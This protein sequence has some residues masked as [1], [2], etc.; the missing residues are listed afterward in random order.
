[1]TRVLTTIHRI[2]LPCAMMFVVPVAV[3]FNTLFLRDSVMS[4]MSDAEYEQ[5][6]ESFHAALEQLQVGETLEWGGT[7]GAH[8]SITLGEDFEYS[9]YTCRNTRFE[10]AVGSQRGTGELRFCKDGNGEWKIL[11]TPR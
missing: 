1:M 11:S 2:V 8:G 10:N 7:D 6:R 9:G 3:A 4:E 5:M